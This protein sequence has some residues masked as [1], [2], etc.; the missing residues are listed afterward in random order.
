MRFVNRVVFRLISDRE[1]HAD[2][3]SVTI[4]DHTGTAPAGG[5]DQMEKCAFVA[6]SPGAMRPSVVVYC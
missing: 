5:N 1:L 2:G 6:C 3:V 4:S